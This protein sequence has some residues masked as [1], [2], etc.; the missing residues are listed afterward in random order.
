M[1]DEMDNADLHS[2]A[3]RKI[4]NTGHSRAGGFVH[5]VAGTYSVFGPMALAAIGKVLPT[6]LMKRCVAI[7]LQRSPKKLP[8]IADMESDPMLPYVM[9]RILKWSQGVTLSGNP[10]LPMINRIADN[11]RPLIAIGDTFPQWS[12]KAREVATSVASQRSQS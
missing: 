7:D 6:P 4:I 11:W 1:L 10:D 12:E 8:S 3:L 9:H 2:G 5:R